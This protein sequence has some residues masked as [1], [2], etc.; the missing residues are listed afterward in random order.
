MSSGKAVYFPFI[1]GLRAIAVVSVILF[2]LNE[3]WLPGGFTGVDIFFVISGFVVSASLANFDKTRLRDFVWFFYARRMQRILPALIVC[4][5]SF[6][7]LSVL[8]IPQ[9]WLSN[10]NP[11]TA[12]WAFFGLSNFVLAADTGDYFA[13][14]SEFN[15]FTHTWSLGVEEQFYFA[16]PL[17]FFLWARHNAQLRD[18][19]IS[20]VLF[21]IG[22]LV[23]LA[24]AIT[25]SRDNPTL[26]F[27]SIFSRFW[28]LASGVLLFQ[29]SCHRTPTPASLR[30][31]WPLFLV[32]V[33]CIIA[34]FLFA[35]PTRFPWPWALLPVVGTVGAIGA[36]VM[37][38]GN[39]VHRLIAHP[40]PTGI[41]K[42]SYSLYLWHWPVIVMM[43]WTIGLEALWHYGLA[44]GLTTIFATLSYHYVEKPIRYARV[45]KN[46]PRP[47][48]VLASLTVV[49]LSVS[50]SQQ[51]FNH[52]TVLSASV[53]ANQTD[54]YP[55]FRAWNP[56]A[57]CVPVQESIPLPAGSIVRFA[58]AHCPNSPTS[59]LFVI[60]DSH[61][62]AYLPL[63]QRISAEEATEVLLYTLAGCAFLSLQKPH[64]SLTGPCR[65][66]VDAAEGDLLQRL[67]PGDVL[68]LP[69][70]RISR[71]AEQF[72]LF[73]EADV[74]VNTFGSGAI[75]ERGLA[76]AEALGLLSRLTMRGVKVLFEAP[77]PVFLSPPFRCSDWF[78]AKNPI[79][80]RGLSMPQAALQRLRAPYLN[81]MEAMT[82]KLD[83]VSI[84]DPFPRLCPGEVCEVAEAGR[85]LFFDA[86][87]LSAY[88]NQVLYPGFSAQLSALFAQPVDQ[89]RQYFRFFIPVTQDG[90][91]WVHLAAAGQPPMRVEAV[92]LT[93]DAMG[94]SDLTRKLPLDRYEGT[95]EFPFTLWAEEG[96]VAVDVKTDELLSPEQMLLEHRFTPAKNALSREEKQ[97][98]R[99]YFALFGL[100]PSKEDLPYWVTQLRKIGNDMTQ[101]MEEMAASKDFQARYG[102]LSTDE[103]V[104]ALYQHL[105]NRA[106][107][108]G[109]L[110]YYSDQLARK[111]VSLPHIA[112][113]ILFGA[114]G[115]DA[116]TLEN[117]MEVLYCLMEE[118]SI[119]HPEARIQ[120]GLQGVTEAPET[121][122]EACRK[123]RRGTESNVEL[124]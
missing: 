56:D 106:P 28:E 5:L 77:K 41:G 108:S 86:D 37:H 12:F 31:F 61:A 59:R 51:V 84:W 123:I 112:G 89:K 97:V 13:P 94:S 119:A 107:D 93:L 109:G 81:A 32:S 115:A 23:S 47:K 117:R 114:E 42:V 60:G 22:L 48:V 40:L 121:R 4:L 2:H 72:S 116:R 70:L 6:S 76:V 78:N 21:F 38:P 63:L 17:L 64:G 35:Q 73:P 69:S 62:G 16:F 53:T 25:L 111:A 87:H 18:K 120:A 90:T 66:F 45:L 95:G 102:E 88:G 10:T 124:D 46:L 36:L 20:S 19:R 7:L 110:A 9:A 103:Q 104:S 99:Y 14:V 83:S 15:P 79:C 29:W 55:E 96:L 58:T 67:Q 118:D 65:E 30:M 33:L 122:I 98:V 26:A 80:V 75:K 43:R 54:W 11:D 50:V 91:L 1:D 52:P 101:M 34:G 92:T 57:P 100:L 49:G 113:D 85:P 8:F 39:P 44:V 68:F 24:Y 82:Q 74:E 105:L 3:R 27:Y 71:F